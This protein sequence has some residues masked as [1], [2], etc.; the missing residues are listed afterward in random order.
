MQENVGSGTF[1]VGE[2]LGLGA[3][4][5]DALDSGDIAA[6]VVGLAVAVA[7]GVP[8]PAIARTAIAAPTSDLTRRA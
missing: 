8:Q 2:L 4:E 5:G 3:S 7:W 6:L 1:A